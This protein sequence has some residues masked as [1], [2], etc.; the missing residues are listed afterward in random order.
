MKSLPISII[1]SLACSICVASQTAR[2][3]NTP[4]EDG[5][6][7]NSS[8]VYRIPAMAKSTNGVIVAVYDCRYN[9]SGDLPNAIDIAENWS[10]DNGAT[11]SKPRVAV[12]VPN[13]NNYQKVCNIG[14]PC[15]VYDPDGDKFWLMGITGGGLASSHDSSGNSIA[16]VVLYTRGTGE[17]DTWQEW[18]G[19]PEGN[20]RSVKQMIL[21]SLVD[22]EGNETY[23]DEN[24]IR[25]ILQGPGHGIVQRQTVYAADGETVLMPAGAIVFPMQYFIDGNFSNTRTFAVYSID[26]GA[27]W[28]STKLTPADCNAQENCIME[29]DDGSWYMIAKGRTTSDKRRQLFRTTDYANWTY[30]GS[31]TPSE[32]VQGSCLRLGEGFD[33]K[34]RYAACFSPASRENITL[35]FGIDTTA[36]DSSG[37]GIAWSLGK[38]IVYPGSTGGMGYNSLVMLDDHTIGIILESSGHIYFITED[39]SDILAIDELPET[40]EDN[41]VVEFNESTVRISNTNATPDVAKWTVSGTPTLEIPANL[42]EKLPEGTRIKLSS[43]DFGYVTD[44][45]GYTHAKKIA[46]SLGGDTWTSSFVVTNETERFP[47]KN[48]ATRARLAYSFEDT[49]CVLTVGE[50]YT[51]SLLDASGNP[52]GNIRYALAQEADTIL[53]GMDYNASYTA[54]FQLTGE[55]LEEKFAARTFDW[56]PGGELKG[57]WFTSWTG[58]TNGPPVT[59][60]GPDG[61]EAQ[62]YVTREDAG[63]IWRPY[64]S[65]AATPLDDFTFVTYGNADNVTASAGKLAVLWCM[66]RRYNE[67]IALVKDESGNIRLVQITGENTTLNKDIVAPP[68][69]GWHLFTVR[70]SSSSGAS[71]QIDDG[72]VYADSTFTTKANV[73]GFQVGSVRSGCTNPLVRGMGFAVLKMLAFDSCD[74]PE[75]QYAA[76]CTEYPGTLQ[77]ESISIDFEHGDGGLDTSLV[78]K[79]GLDGYKVPV[80]CWNTLLATNNASLAQLAALQTD[81]V[82]VSRS[83]MSVT[84]SGTRG[85]YKCEKLDASDNPLYGYIDDDDNNKTPSVTVTG[86]PYDKYRVIVYHSTDQANKPFGYDL[87]NGIPFTGRSGRTTAGTMNWGDS[88][89]YK[90]ANSLEEG[91]NALVTPILHNNAEATLTVTGHRVS[92]VTRGCIAAIQIFDATD[93]TDDFSNTTNRVSSTYASGVWSFPDDITAADPVKFGG[94]IIGTNAVSQSLG[95][96]SASTVSA[97]VLAEIPETAAGTLISL[98][99]QDGHS[100]HAIYNGNG[101]FGLSY[102]TAGAVVTNAPIDVAGVHIWTLA[103]DT[104]NGAAFY[105]D[106]VKVVETSRIKWTY[107]SVKKIAGSVE[108]GAKHDQSDP[109]TGTIIYAA[110]TDFSDALASNAGDVVSSVYTEQEIPGVSGLATLAE[111]AELFTHLAAYGDTEGLLA[112]MPHRTSTYGHDAWHSPLDAELADGDYVDGLKTLFN[113]VVQKLPGVSTNAAAAS[114]LAQIPQ[115]ASGVIANITVV[116]GSSTHCVFA[117][118]NGDGTVSLGWENVAKRTTS[119]TLDGWDSIHVWTLVSHDSQGCKLYRDGERVLEDSGLKFNGYKAGASIMFGNATNSKHPLAGMNA[120]AVHTD[121]GSSSA[122]F[123]TAEESAASVFDSFDFMEELAGCPPQRC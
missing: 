40:D 48:S 88:G 123:D 107:P 98:G 74:M 24:Q 6:G 89:P 12:D 77:P 104:S 114:V 66:G 93:E 79:I 96:S 49:D 65:D 41:L 11:W 106:G 59:M 1:L 56:T 101:T 94:M 36:A 4:Y 95:S 38:R 46:L 68:V 32:W 78:T 19:G 3:A 34:G 39:I 99:V 103:F 27:T 43:L 122:I 115:T 9:S 29:L 113:P 92:G 5:L 51:L 17:N 10:G 117:R 84:V 28:R 72:R 62:I 64:C 33:G 118:A 37:N 75:A 54:M 50:S 67:K 2:L 52:L 105:K 7:T 87:V 80:N 22:V 42:R 91:V 35:H 85:Y 69:S 16:D 18:T 31:I 57:S 30:C 119:E 73:A 21:N 82:T 102:D 15:I 14:D 23:R 116:N 110:R 83:G 45:N 63:G 100:V 55:I 111:K 26:G 8:G 71:L 60:A 13:T 44:N 112:L 97:T 81:G 86:I 61:T 47:A 120:Y 121:F 76:L 20:R 90:S 109:L 25:G 53:G 108:F 70:F 58:E